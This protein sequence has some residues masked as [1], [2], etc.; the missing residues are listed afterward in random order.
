MRADDASQATRLAHTESLAQL[1]QLTRDALTTNN[2]I[3]R[4]K[5]IVDGIEQEQNA[6]NVESSEQHKN[7]KP[8][9]VYQ[10]VY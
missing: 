2:T 10:Y 9:A 8:T 4:T 1:G 7:L 5:E 3:K 6:L